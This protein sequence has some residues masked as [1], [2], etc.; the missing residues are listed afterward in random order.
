[1]INLCPGLLTGQGDLVKIHTVQELRQRLDPF[2]L[3][4]A[5]ERILTRN[6]ASL[7]SPSGPR[8]APSEALLRQHL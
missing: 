4:K 6:R 2:A 8:T 7:L 1:M 3:A 5:T